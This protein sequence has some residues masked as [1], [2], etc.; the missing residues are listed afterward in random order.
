MRVQVTLGA[1]AVALAAGTFSAQQQNQFV[2]KWEMTGTG[3]DAN[4]IYFLD[5]VDKGDHLEA[6]FLDRS[7]HATPVPWIKVANG[8]LSWQKGNSSDSLPQPS[9]GPIYHAKL[10]GGKLVGH[11]E[12]PGTSGYSSEAAGAPCPSNRGGGAEIGRAHV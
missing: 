5:V 7:A 11:H 10:E 8:E 2:G 12:E 3:P 9:C 4:K 6:K 1:L